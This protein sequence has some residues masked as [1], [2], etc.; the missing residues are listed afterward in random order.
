[1]TMSATGPNW[2]HNE[3]VSEE[4]AADST[5]LVEAES[6]FKRILHVDIIHE[7]PLEECNAPNAVGY[8]KLLQ[9]FWGKVEGHKM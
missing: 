7:R 8:F 1:M 9:I 4:I 5:L 3:M 2:T 6:L